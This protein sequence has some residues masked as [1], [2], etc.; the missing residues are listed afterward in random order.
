MGTTFASGTV[1]VATITL[2]PKAG[3]TFTGVTANYFGVT[4]APVAPAG[5]SNPANSGVVTATYVA[6]DTTPAVVS[7]VFSDS[8]TITITY[9]VAVNSTLV[10][11]QGVNAIN[12]VYPG[13]SVLTPNQVDG[14]TTK[15]ISITFTSASGVYATNTSTG[16]LDLKAT[17]CSKADNTLKLVAVNNQAIVAGGF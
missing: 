9:N 12:M 5:V 2:V 1:Y 7:A 17:I 11:Y 13:A 14:T 4:A 8:D 16:T 3:F 6:T 15:Y 10:D